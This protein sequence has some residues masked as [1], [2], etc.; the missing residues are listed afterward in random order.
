MYLIYAYRYPKFPQLS[1]NRSARMGI[2][3]HLRATTAWSGRLSGATGVSKTYHL[4]KCRLAA[5]AISSS[6]VGPP[7][8]GSPFPDCQVEIAQ[9]EEPASLA[10]LKIDR[11]V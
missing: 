6:G 8:P 2:T 4:Q 5:Q 1:S 3:E 11:I 7:V 10:E 9:H